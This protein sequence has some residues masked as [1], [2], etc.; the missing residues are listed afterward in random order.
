MF[1]GNSEADGV[2]V[3]FC[4]DLKYNLKHYSTNIP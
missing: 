1:A 3:H 2:I 4:L